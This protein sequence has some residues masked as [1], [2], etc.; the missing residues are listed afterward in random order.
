MQNQ[1]NA[2]Y[3]LVPLRVSHAHVLVYE[4]AVGCCKPQ[5]SREPNQKPK[6]THPLPVPTNI[7]PLHT[8]KLTTKTS[9]TGM[10]T[11]AEI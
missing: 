3:T 5:F 8:T 7:P 2:M 1:Y 6:T 11:E 4:A 10:L 9:Y